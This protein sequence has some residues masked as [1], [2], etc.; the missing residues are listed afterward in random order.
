MASRNEFGAEP[1][2]GGGFGAGVGDD[3]EDMFDQ[4]TAASVVDDEISEAR[5]APSSAPAPAP[6]VAEKSYFDTAPAVQEEIT[7]SFDAE[8]DE[9]SSFI[10]SSDTEAMFTEAEATS[11]ADDE[12]RESESPIFDSFESF[13]I[14][15][16]AVEDEPPVFQ[17]TPEPEL[18]PE[19]EEQDSF[20]GW[21]DPALDLDLEP[22]VVESPP[23]AVVA[24]IAP[25]PAPAAAEPAPVAQPEAVYFEPTIAEPIP[26]VVAERTAPPSKAPVVSRTEDDVDY[27]ERVILTSDAIRDLEEED[28]KAVNMF[29]TAGSPVETHQELVL[30]SLL[31]DRQILKTA[32]AILES[33][34]KSSVDMAFHI[35]GLDEATFVDFGKILSHDLQSSETV[36]FEGDRLRY[37]RKLV[38]VV[39][40]LP[41]VS[42]KRFEAVRS[43]LGAGELS[44]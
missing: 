29:V 24:P 22:V 44:S 2:S 42:I 8:E 43:V 40:A 26:S 10:A 3:F 12:I 1:S 9:A 18:Q 41:P 37:A 34:V 5:R 19:P 14:E 7:P 17:P 27:I 20:N 28:A 4:A 38:D 35:L 23:V 21:S 6:V 33:K 13:G 15:S 36:I 16:S 31:A 32:E 39:E 25:A 11:V 30:T